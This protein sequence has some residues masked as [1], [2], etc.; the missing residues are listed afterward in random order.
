MTQF[1]GT[2]LLLWIKSGSSSKLDHHWIIIITASALSINWCYLSILLVIGSSTELALLHV[3]CRPSLHVG[4]H[5]LQHLYLTMGGTHPTSILDGP[6][7]TYILPWRNTSSIRVRKDRRTLRSNHGRNTSN[8][9]IRKAQ[10][11]HMTMGGTHPA[12]MS[13]RPA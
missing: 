12:S 1:I 4:L 9:H 2:S 7:N 8:I 11:S 5:I 3:G 6:P 10:H 13:E